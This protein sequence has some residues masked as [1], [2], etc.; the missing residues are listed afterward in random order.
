MSAM[1]M[2]QIIDLIKPAC[3]GQSMKQYYLLLCVN[4]LIPTSIVIPRRWDSG[5]LSKHAVDWIVDRTFAKLVFPASTCPQIAIF[6][7][8]LFSVY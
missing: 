2:P 1:Y 6:M 4:P 8:V 5:C 3:P 7:K